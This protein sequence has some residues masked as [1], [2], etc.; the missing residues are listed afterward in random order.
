MVLVTGGTGFIGRA[1]VKWLVRLGKP[2]RV[3]TRDP[4]RARAVLGNLPVELV[5]GS[6]GDP[7]SLRAAMEGVRTVANCVQLE[8]APTENPR[9]GLTYIEVDGKGTIR[10][11][12]AAK[13]TGVREFLYLSGAGAGQGRKENWFVAK[14]MAE[15][16]IQE[17]GLSYVIWRPS[18]VYGPADRSVNRFISMARRLPFVPLIG[19]G[20]Q[21][22]QPLYV[23]DLVSI[24]AMSL[25]NAAAQNRIFEAGGPEVFTMRNL[26]ERILGVLGKRKPVVPFPIP[27][28]RP[29]S[30]L[31]RYIPGSGISPQVVDF[32]LQEA[33]VD[34]TALLSTFDV[35]L[36]PFREALRL[37]AARGEAKAQ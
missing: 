23:E 11:V 35:K 33:V 21:R 15:K 24:I 30:R 10:Q 7:E 17:S 16:A 3:M 37:Y 8:N 18:W 31:L 1:V 22:V 20:S 6:V 29:A 27:L 28:V 32:S 13:E 14:D 36:T 19:D 5:R 4:G 9:K 25:G 34:N 26:V 12:E 2:V